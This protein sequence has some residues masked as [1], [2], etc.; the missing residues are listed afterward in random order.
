[1]KALIHSPD[2][3]KARRHELQERIRHLNEA[4]ARHETRIAEML[5]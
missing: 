4:L 2:R 3:I 1:V 5:E